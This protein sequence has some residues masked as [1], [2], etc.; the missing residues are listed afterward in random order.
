MHSHKFGSSFRQQT[1]YKKINKKN[2]VE[3]IGIFYIDA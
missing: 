3:P 1:N 2:R